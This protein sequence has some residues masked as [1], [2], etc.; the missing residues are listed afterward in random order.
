MEYMLW[1]CIPPR[2]IE[3][4]H[5]VLILQQVAQK[6]ARFSQ[7]LRKQSLSW[8]IRTRKKRASIYPNLTIR[9]S[10]RKKLRSRQDETIS[11]F[12]VLVASVFH[13]HAHIQ[14]AASCP[15]TLP[16]K[17]KFGT[18]TTLYTSNFCKKNCI[19]AV[20]GF[21]AVSIEIEMIDFGAKFYHIS[22]FKTR[23]IRPFSFFFRETWCKW[24]TCY[25]DVFHQELSKN[26]TRCWFCS[27]LRK[28]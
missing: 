16:I 19:S 8:V 18:V 7:I 12:N 17:I 9:K 3:K 26:R 1:W 22:D 5:T 27:R 25:G 21:R 11:L 6:V 13:F 15:C 24:S 23:P 14:V 10:P 20:S 4:S 2:I 28:M